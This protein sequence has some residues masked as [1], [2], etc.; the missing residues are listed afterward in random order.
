ML[1]FNRS[2][3]QLADLAR[4]VPR[5]P[6]LHPRD[7]P[8]RPAYTTEDLFVAGRGQRL[9]QGKGQ[10]PLTQILRAL[11]MTIPIALNVPMT[12]RSKA[13]GPRAT[14]ALAL[15]ATRKPLRGLPSCREGC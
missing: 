11:P 2:D 9:P 10:I 14:A 5:M 15:E 8:V 4:A 13:Q 3:S 7:A 1:H 6:F 12:G